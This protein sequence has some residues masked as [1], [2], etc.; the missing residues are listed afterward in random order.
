MPRAPS[1]A[2]SE[3]PAHI[4]AVALKLFAERGIDGVTVRQIAEAAGQKN[5]AALTYYFGSKEAL[6]REL[7][8]DGAR[9]I[10]ERRNAAL[11]GSVA[12][13]GPRSVVEVMEILVETSVDPDP[14]PWGECY[15]RFI[16]GL[17]LS[18]RALFMDALAGRWNSGYQRCLD[19]VRRLMPEAPPDLLNQRLVF[20]GGAINGILAGRETELA[21]RSRQ[22][23]MWSH[24]ETLGRVA[25]A[26]ASIIE[27]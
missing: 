14:P 1:T 13:G 27:G 23:P 9:A 5:H 21:D 8:V 18:N 15:N 16:V 6:I 3:A 22:H 12:A 7:I 11:D 10:D 4:R 19:E 2:H 24:A 26:L 20:M 25:R 17:Q